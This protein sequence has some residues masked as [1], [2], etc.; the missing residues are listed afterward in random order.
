MKKIICTEC[1]KFVDYK[2]EFKE[3]IVLVKDKEIRY[4]KKEAYCYTSN[5]YG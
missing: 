3:E 5:S 1:R 2:I 4:N